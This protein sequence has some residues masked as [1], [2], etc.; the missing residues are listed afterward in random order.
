MI[1]IGGENLPK[2]ISSG[3]GANLAKIYKSKGLISIEDGLKEIYSVLNAK[4]KIKQINPTQFEVTIRHHNNFCPIGGKYEPEKAELIQK[5]IC[6]PYTNGFL[7][8]LNPMFKYR[9]VI[10]ECIL[11]NKGDYCR[12][13]LYLEKK[14]L[15]NKPDA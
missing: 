7:N 1:D 5:S 6:V 8:E 15:N 4:I 13:T 10:H 11:S 9:G 2:T 14:E 12:Y 3:L